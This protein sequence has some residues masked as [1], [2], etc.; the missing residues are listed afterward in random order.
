[1]A[2]PA[3]S[4]SLVSL[5]LST[6]RHRQAVT[7]AVA[8]GVATATAVITGALLVGDSMRGSLRSLTVERLGKIESIV[9]PGAFFPLAE[10]SLAGEPVEA[11]GNVSGDTTEKDS[12][13]TPVILFPGGSVEADVEGSDRQRR[14]GGVQV[15]GIEDSFWDLDVTG[16]K[17][18]AMPGEQSVVL[19]QAAA[20]ELKVAV[21]DQVTLRLPVEGAV[22][23]DSPLG[24]R[25][26]QSEGLPR[27][28]V[29]AIVP[30]TGLGRFSL[31]PNQAA[32]KTVFA[33]REVIA[34]VLDRD[35]QA[36]AI[37]LTRE[38]SADEIGWSLETLGWNLQHIQRGG[39][40]GGE[41]IIDYVSLT[42][43]NLLLKDDAVQAVMDALPEGTVTPVMTYL[44]NAIE[45]VD[46]ATGEVVV[47]EQSHSVPYS[48]LSALDDGPT[49]S[50]DYSLPQPLATDPGETP[51]VLNDW[52][53][54]RLGAKVGDQVRVFF[55]E[56]EVEDGREI[57]RSFDAVVTEIVP[58][59]IPSKPYRRNREAVFDGP[60]TPY[61]DLALTPDVPGVTD[62]DSIGDWDLPFQL[63]RKIEREDDAYWN[64][65]RLTPKAFL[66][67]GAGQTIFGSRFGKTTGLRIDASLAADMPGLRAKILAATRSV[68]GELG[69]TPRSIRAEQLAASKGT[70]PFDGLFL[71]LS[72]FVILAA[73]MLIALLLRLGVLQ[74]LSEFGTLLAV[75]FTP[76][77]VMKLALGETAVTAAIGTLIGI[78]GGV[79]YAWAVL[80]ALKSWWVGAVTVPFLQFH[81][82]PM[83]IALGGILGWLVCMLTAA[84]TLRFL[85]RLNPA[86]LVGGRTMNS[87]Q[88]L[89]GGAKASQRSGGNGSR[90][91][92]I[93]LTVL[94]MVAA[95][96]GAMGGGQQAA[97]GFVGAGMLLLVAILIGV[98]RSL[99]R[100][101]DASD[102]G[103]AM[104]TPG[105]GGG[106]LSSLAMA[107]ARRSPLR[108]TLA[109]GLVAT[110]AFLILSISVFRL[111]PT[112]EGTGG[113]D[114]IGQTAQPLHQDLRADDVRAELLGRDAERFSR[115]DVRVVPFRMKGGDDASCNNLYQAMRPTV[116]GL[117]EDDSLDGFGWASRQGETSDATW[118]LL[119]V[120]ATGTLEDP[121]PVVIDQNTAM[122]SLQMRGGLGEVKAFDYGRGDVHFR[123]VG[124]LAGSVL[125]GKLIVGERAFESV[126]PS[127]T[128]Y[129]YFLFAMEEGADA[130][131]GT[132]ADPTS[133]DEEVD[134]IAEVL[135]SRLVDAGMDVQRADRVLAGLLAVQNTYLRTFQSLGALGLLLGTIGLAVAQLRSVLERRGEL[136]VMRAVGFTR[137]RLAALVLGENTFL[138]AIGIGCGA[139]TAMLAVLPYAWLTGAKMP[140]AE[141]L[142]ILLAILLFG[143]LAGLVAVWKVLTL[144]LIESLRAENAVVEL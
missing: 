4:V 100:R 110:A 113:F 119:N 26:I 42:S 46:P 131:A 38:I 54:E 21:G 55:Y 81:A 13:A 95:I 130:S 117:S 1:M 59:T 90:W 102:A 36:N 24:R 88:A 142:G 56:P 143:T 52:T 60:I 96:A 45:K 6:L 32:P 51:I 68:Q 65:Q 77:R 78:A 29:A 12:F 53:A 17:P 80:W 115:E 63:D 108:S 132:P 19:N 69:W 11:D 67:L 89:S 5:I 124:L 122:W 8:L 70:T 37:F 47:N 23:A 114:L 118:E 107:N 134:E 9:S 135:E 71:A 16:M 18:G 133:R 123:V 20:E 116:L 127:S 85:L 106:A 83:S 111:S 73:M 28:K 74:R 141:P 34:D 22:P 62:Q 99:R 98:H 138:L 112:R 94:A 15:L 109:I 103:H 137:Q 50:L 121:V 3:R 84:W 91:F 136:A 126:F 140:I 2:S 66:P 82:T 93:G 72:F 105:L 97:G 43:E 10:L 35:G 25:E 7:V 49:L 61:N 79:A 86:A 48:T 14:I 64:E 129:Q 31:S 104:R 144:P 57:E 39:E 75:G 40:D 101:G 76:R 92:A 120:V 87:S 128:G 33:S 58:L 139:V 44:A 30:D 41:P 125:Q 27:M